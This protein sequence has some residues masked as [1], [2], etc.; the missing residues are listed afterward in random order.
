MFKKIQNKIKKNFEIFGLVF[1]ILVSI[2]LTSYFNFQK[3][4][5]DESYTSF[6]E[7]IYFKYNK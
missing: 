3:K 7:N 4:I 6:T 5:L 1:L 2:V